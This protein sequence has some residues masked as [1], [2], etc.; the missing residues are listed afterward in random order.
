MTAG[1]KWDRFPLLAFDL[2]TTGINVHEDHVVQSALVKVLPDQRPEITTW[3]VN[4]GVEI[5]DEAAAVHGIT[6]DHA[7]A[8]GTDPAQMLYELTGR[9]ALWLGNG[10][11]IV[12]M[13]LAYDLTL[14]EAENRRHGIDTLLDRLGPGHIQPVIDVMVLD[15]YVDKFRK[16]GRRLE[17]LCE[18]Y[19][20]RHVGA[21]DAA[22]DALATARIFPRLMAK[23]AA[24]FRGFTLGA[25]HQAQIG[26]RR[27]QMDGLRRYFEKNGIEHDG[28]NGDWPIQRPPV[29]TTDAQGALL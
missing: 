26:W 8:H 29:T 25:L 4:P 15:K 2:E 6:T 9:L 22:G 3:L 21:H 28:C 13:N 11:P 17:N 14:L 12:G 24:K 19:G 10:K 7:Q 20:V 27:D 23:H 18:V 5:P 16:G 1:Q